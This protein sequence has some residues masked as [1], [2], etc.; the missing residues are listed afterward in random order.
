MGWNHRCALR[1]AGVPEHTAMLLTGHKT[2]TIFRRYDIH[3]MDDL[4]AVRQSA[5]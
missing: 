1:R 5:D 3:G 4:R 2:P